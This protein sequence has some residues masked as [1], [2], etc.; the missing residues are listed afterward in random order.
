MQDTYILELGDEQ[1]KEEEGKL[2]KSKWSRSRGKGGTI[3]RDEK[4]QK[5]N[6]GTERGKGQDAKG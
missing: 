2:I 6:H 5:A 4:R 3:K 1:E